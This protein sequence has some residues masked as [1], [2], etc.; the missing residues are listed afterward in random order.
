MARTTGYTL[1]ETTIGPFTIR[2]Q[3]AK[4]DEWVVN[5]WQIFEGRHFFGG[6][7]DSREDAIEAA[8][9]AH[10]ERLR[11]NLDAILNH[12]SDDNLTTIARLEAALDA[13]NG[14]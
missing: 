4:G 6:S 3:V 11:A 13:L 14:A 12:L 7:F 1:T 10:A 9:E 5:E 8:C 2:R